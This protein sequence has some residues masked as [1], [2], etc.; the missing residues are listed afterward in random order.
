MFVRL[1]SIV[2]ALGMLC[3]FS[4]AQTAKAQ[5]TTP[6]ADYQAQIQDLSASTKAQIEALE[7]QIATAT[8]Q[9]QD[10]LQLQIAE[11]KRQGEI[12]R[13]E[14]LLQWAQDKGDAARVAEIEQAL[15]NWRNPPQPQALP[16]IEKHA[17]AQST[18]TSSK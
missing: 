17:P 16:Q 8:P 12:S 13:L 14:I 9:H 3:S 5:A 4:F 2:L 1:L 7:A 6:R 11:T 18:T 15:N 10:E